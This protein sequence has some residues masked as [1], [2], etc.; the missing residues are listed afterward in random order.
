MTLAPLEPRK[1]YQSVTGVL[2]WSVFAVHIY[3]SVEERIAIFTLFGVMW[4]G[5]AWWEKSWGVAHNMHYATKIIVQGVF[6]AV[7]LIDK[8]LII[9]RIR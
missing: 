5:G 7:S 2:G 8:A 4:R 6:V 1:I 3:L 9:C